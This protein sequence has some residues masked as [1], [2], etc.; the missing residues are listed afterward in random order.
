MAEYILDVKVNTKN[1]GVSLDALQEHL[2]EI[3]DEAAETERAIEELAQTERGRF[4]TR[5]QLEEAVRTAR[6]AEAETL[7]REFKYE[8][9]LKKAQEEA[10]R[11]VEKDQQQAELQ[12]RERERDR[13]AQLD[14]I[15]DSLSYVRSQALAAGLA[16]DSL[17]SALID[18]ASTGFDLAKIL[19]AGQGAAISAAITGALAAYKSFSDYQR[20]NALAQSFQ[21]DLAAV[22][23][24]QL[25]IRELGRGAGV[26]L[27]KAAQEAKLTRGELS[28][29]ALE[30]ARVSRET[31]KSIEEGIGEAL[32]RVGPSVSELTERL[33]KAGLSAREAKLESLAPKE[34]FTKALAAAGRVQGDLAEATQKLAASEEILA[35]ARRRSESARD[36]SGFALL[37]LE[38]EV[39]ANRARIDEIKKADA[40]IA[41]SLEARNK[42]VSEATLREGIARAKD[43]SEQLSQ[44]LQGRERIIATY[45]KSRLE[46]L[47]AS[48]TA[49]ND[50]ERAAVSRQLGEIQGIRDRD[51]RQFNQQQI[52]L[53][54]EAQNQL[55]DAQIEALRIAGR[56]RQAEEILIARQT[57]EAIAEIEQDT[58][59]NKNQ[60]LVAIRA[61]GEQRLSNL[62]AKYAKERADRDQ[63]LLEE[64]L[65]VA[66]QYLDRRSELAIREEQR[67]DATAA[68]EILAARR[69][70]DESRRAAQASASLR[71]TSAEELAAE[72]A[73]IEQEFGQKTILIRSASADRAAEAEER[74][75]AASE[76]RRAARA[77]SLGIGGGDAASAAL[78]NLGLAQDQV[79]ALRLSFADMGAA[80]AS[81][82]SAIATST[83][84][85]TSAL[86]AVQGALTASVQQALTDNGYAR[87]L[88][89][90]QA[91]T[92]KVTTDEQ[93]ASYDK[94]IAAS[95]SRA[96]R[97]ALLA[98]REIRITKLRKEAKRAAARDEAI[99]GKRA[100]AALI[101][102]IA[103]QA[104]VK[105]A[106]TGAEAAVAF[107]LGLP[108]APALAAAAAAYAAIGGVAAGASKALGTRARTSKEQAS[109]A[110]L[111]RQ[112]EVSTGTGSSGGDAA[113]AARRSEAFARRSSGAA[114]PVVNLYFAGGI[115][116]PGPRLGE[117]LD[118]ARAAAERLR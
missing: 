18:I 44:L 70:A 43:E 100:T 80:G 96:Q 48:A 10:R 109:L 67:V 29:L 26:S 37:A 6:E 65:A 115:L 85:A 17:A 105:A 116:P 51:L 36:G 50:Q 21:L 57:Q 39:K 91:I 94:Q 35:A 76:A 83:E 33:R 34:E 82:W 23:Q 90:E 68:S 64:R 71:I 79:T 59:E 113:A 54:R 98:Q 46:I 42:L 84:V 110:D 111:R 15:G 78:S 106:F 24:L 22:E 20:Q 72:L 93:I 56:E 5:A 81:A 112:R 7:R 114:Q 55:G 97:E 52:K 107:A 101:A 27:A 25:G 69:A 9:G 41:A 104:V 92:T 118:Q 11:K 16:G 32:K 49:I 103:A 31:G 13:R 74:K 61:A 95:T 63:A 53:V 12:A 19:G 86:S 62:A 2:Q 30:A 45:E 28:L 117:Y 60:R 99:E 4:A 47:R 40:A 3:A 58:N 14:D 1:S 73:R 108:N 66:R 102:Q 87:R 77:T 88:A 89:E 75:R 38:N 8:E